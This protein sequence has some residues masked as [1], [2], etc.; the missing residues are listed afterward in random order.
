MGGGGL[1]RG[2]K[3]TL[4]KIWACMWGCLCAGAYRWRNAAYMHGSGNVT[5]CSFS[6]I[7]TL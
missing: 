3:H 4:G 7:E 6:P 5:L 1:L 2:V